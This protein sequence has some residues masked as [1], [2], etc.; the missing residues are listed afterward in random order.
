MLSFGAKISVWASGDCKD[1]VVSWKGFN[2]LLVLLELRWRWRRWVG[3]GF[4]VG[5]GVVLHWVGD[6]RNCWGIYYMW[7]WRM[8]CYLWGWRRWRMVGCGIVIWLVLCWRLSL[9]A[10]VCLRW[11]SERYDGE[12][13]WWLEVHCMVWFT[14][15]SGGWCEGWVG[16][17]S[18]FRLVSRKMGQ[19]LVWWL[20]LLSWYMRYRGFAVYGPRPWP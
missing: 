16:S 11:K 5:L 4:N 13:C 8:V 10:L 3:F 18:I 9:V 1:C 6:L 7:S 19:S 20:V 12:Y 2:L 14:S 17:C 15:L